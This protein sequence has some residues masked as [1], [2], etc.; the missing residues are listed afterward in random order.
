MI[1]SHAEPRSLKLA[2]KHRI[3]EIVSGQALPPPRKRSMHLPSF[4]DFRPNVE[5]AIP[6]LARNASISVKSCEISWVIPHTYMGYIPLVNGK[7]LKCN[8]RLETLKV[9]H[10]KNLARKT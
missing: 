7:S 2:M 10:E 9:G 3:D 1:L 6:V 5:G 4:T 8:R